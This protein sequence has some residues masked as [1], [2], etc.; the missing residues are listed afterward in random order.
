M[1]ALFDDNAVVVSVLALFDDNAVG[2]SLFQV[3]ASLGIKDVTMKSWT[4]SM[5]SAAKF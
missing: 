5:V 4:L 3:V 1:L 2:V